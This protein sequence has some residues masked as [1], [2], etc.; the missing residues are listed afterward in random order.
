[1]NDDH[2]TPF[3]RLDQT[4]ERMNSG[5]T[6]VAAVLGLMVA[7]IGVIRAAEMGTNLDA[8]ASSTAHLP[9]HHPT[10]NLSTH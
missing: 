2:I 10:F 7:C 1:M 3:R 6:A 5:L 9:N 4:C 8:I